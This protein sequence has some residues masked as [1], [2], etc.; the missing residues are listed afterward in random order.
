MEHS[1]LFMGPMLGSIRGM[2]QLTPRHCC[3]SPTVFV[4]RS[5]SEHHVHQPCGGASTAGNIQDNTTS[6]RKRLPAS[7]H[8]Q[9]SFG[10][11]ASRHSTA[12]KDTGWQIAMQRPRQ[13]CHGLPYVP[14]QRQTSTTYHLDLPSCQTS[15]RPATVLQSGLPAVTHSLS[16]TA[17]DNTR[18]QKYTHIHWFHH[19]SV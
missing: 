18:Q 16:Q 6:D 2:F 9:A 11:K 15:A 4:T 14:P 13:Q 19:R 12:L 8:I 1:P 17:Q 10:A 5:D 3:S 7:L